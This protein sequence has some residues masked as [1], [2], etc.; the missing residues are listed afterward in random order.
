MK[1][2]DKVLSELVSYEVIT[3]D[4]ADF[5]KSQYS[6]FVTTVLKENRP[7]FLNYSKTYQGLD[8]F[9]MKFDGASTTFS[10]LC[11]LFKIL[12]ILLHGQ[13]QVK[14]GFSVNKNLLAENQHTAT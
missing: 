7:E 13:A 10:E 14:H 4:T 11:K 9:M 3:A 6:K 1:L 2:F 12:L 5:S 8:E